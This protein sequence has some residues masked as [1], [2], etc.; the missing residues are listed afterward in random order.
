MHLHRVPSLNAAT[1]RSNPRPTPP[2]RADRSPEL[3][4]R[5]ARRSPDD[6]PSEGRHPDLPSSS[7]RASARSVPTPA[8]AN[9]APGRAERAAATS[10][11]NLDPALLD[12]LTDDVIRRVER[13]VRIE[14]ERRGL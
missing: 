1:P 13:R 2:V 9:E 6:A 10:V 12:R 11:T 4:W 5:R 8:A 14:R 7:T 3:V